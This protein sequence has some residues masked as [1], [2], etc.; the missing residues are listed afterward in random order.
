MINW[1]KWTLQGL[2]GLPKWLLNGKPVHL[3]QSIQTFQQSL[4]TTLKVLSSYCKEKA[5]LA[6][7]EDWSA[8]NRLIQSVIDGNTSIL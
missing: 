3:Q 6:V 5:T 1:V 8:K 2:F 7:S 4:Q